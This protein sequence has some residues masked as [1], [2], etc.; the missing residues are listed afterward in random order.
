VNSKQKIKSTIK[1]KR[2]KNWWSGN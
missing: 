2:I 1:Q